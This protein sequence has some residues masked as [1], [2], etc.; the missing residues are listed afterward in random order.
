[1]VCER[2]KEAGIFQVRAWSSEDKIEAVLMW[3]ALG[4]GI[5]PA[6]TYPQGKEVKGFFVTKVL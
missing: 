6:T 5:C 4:F 1:M 3:K 2:A